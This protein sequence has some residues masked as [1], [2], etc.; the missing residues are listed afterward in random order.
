MVFNLTF[1]I[2][3]DHPATGNNCKNV[4]PVKCSCIVLLLQLFP[5]RSSHIAQFPLGIINW[6]HRLISEQ[7][8]KDIGAPRGW[9][10]G[11]YSSFSFPAHSMFI[12]DVFWGSLGTSIYYLS[13]SYDYAKSN[14]SY[15]KLLLLK[16]CLSACQMKYNQKRSTIWNSSRVENWCNKRNFWWCHP[17]VVTSKMLIFGGERRNYPVNWLQKRFLNDEMNKIEK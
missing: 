9:T 7:L 10:H 16:I 2:F 6:K 17:T 4:P 15:S 8:N 14:H 1:Q 13:V 3:L 5:K 12:F 11:E